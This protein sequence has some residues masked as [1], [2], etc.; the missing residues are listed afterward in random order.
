MP[1]PMEA[2]RD[3]IF[4]TT[5]IILFHVAPNSSKLMTTCVLFFIGMLK[6]LPGQH[7][8]IRKKKRLRVNSYFIV[9]IIHVLH[10]GCNNLNKSKA[11]IVLLINLPN[12]KKLLEANFNIGFS[13]LSVLTRGSCFSP[14]S[15]WNQQGLIWFILIVQQI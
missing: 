12:G 2:L 6:V 3:Q 11:W 10:L 8:K 13:K 1:Q 9:W 4:V 15:S 14:P 5:D 7:I